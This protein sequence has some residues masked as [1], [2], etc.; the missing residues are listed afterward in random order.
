MCRFAVSLVI[1]VNLATIAV[2]CIVVI[3]R[4]R[5]VLKA[6]D[7]YFCYSFIAGNQLLA[8]ASVFT[9]MAPSD[10][11]C[12]LEYGCLVLALSL[13]TTTLT[14]RCCRIYLLFSAKEVVIKPRFSWIYS[15]VGQCT[16]YLSCSAVNVGIAVYLLKSHSVWYLLSPQPEAHQPA[17][18]MCSA[19]NWYNGIPFILPALLFLATLLLSY[20][21]R[22]YPHNF[23]E[24]K[25]IF[26]ATVIILVSVATFC[27]GYSLAAPDMKAFTRCIIMLI[28]TL[29]LL[30]S[31][32]LPKFRMLFFKKLDVASERKAIQE[33]VSTFTSKTVM[34]ETTRRRQN[35]A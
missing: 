3:Y 25:S 18:L 6:S 12:G 13:I 11:I 20:I 32:F 21:M 14:L 27:T 9:I 24:T 4:K 15:L 30:G 16:I 22:D 23:R 7:I 28:S 10:F 34:R 5:P 8:I 1:I 2:L 35:S 33:S 17:Q 31:L 26:L 19:D 29:S